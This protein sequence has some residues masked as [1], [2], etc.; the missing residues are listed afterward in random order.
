M[1]RIQ[2]EIIMPINYSKQGKQNK[3]KGTQAENDSAK[4][5][6]KKLDTDVRR[7]PRSG[8]ILGWPGDLI[9]MGNSILKDFVIDSKTGAT[10]IPK[11]IESQMSKLKDESQGKMYFL[12]I[13]DLNKESLIIIP[14]KQFA[15]LLEE[16]QN[17]KI[18]K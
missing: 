14:R 18:T 17:N 2:K 16:L 15:N 12:E 9:D 7:T 8:A 4:F 13:S 6:S 5:W 1:W 3:K 11:K 10:A